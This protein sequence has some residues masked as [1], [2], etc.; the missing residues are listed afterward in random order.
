[1]ACPLCHFLTFNLSYSCCPWGYPSPRTG[2]TVLFLAKDSQHH[3]S[4][5]EPG[6]LG[7][8][9][10]THTTISPPTRRRQFRAHSWA[11]FL[12]PLPTSFLALALPVWRGQDSRPKSSSFSVFPSSS[13]EGSGP[14]PVHLGGSPQQSAPAYL[15]CRCSSCTCR[16][17]LCSV[18]SSSDRCSFRAWLWASSSW[19]EQTENVRISSGRVAWLSYFPCS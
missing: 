7:S 17:S 12:Q 4:G 15:D 1:M 19:G 2:V 16:F 3:W 8:P 11:V 10:H 14:C 5:P 6:L 18:C 13:L 9:P